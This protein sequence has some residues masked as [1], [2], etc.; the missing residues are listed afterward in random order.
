[1]LRFGHSYL[2]S[3]RAPA[4]EPAS[5]RPNAEELKLLKMLRVQ[6]RAE[7]R[8]LRVGV[9]VLVKLFCVVLALNLRHKGGRELLRLHL[10]P[11]ETAEPLV[12]LDIITA[13]S[14]RKSVV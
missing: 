7:R 13:I 2:Y 3:P 10:H 1:M 12:L 11:V 6:L 14:D 8:W 4:S 9:R 5:A